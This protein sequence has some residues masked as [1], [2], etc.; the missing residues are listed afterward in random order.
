VTPSSTPTQSAR[1]HLYLPVTLASGRD[2]TVAHQPGAALG[3]P[4]L[5]T[6]LRAGADS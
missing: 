5:P 6:V 2:Q 4:F 1:A 3:E